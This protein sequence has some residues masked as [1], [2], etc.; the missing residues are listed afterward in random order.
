MGTIEIGTRLKGRPSGRARKTGCPAGMPM[1]RPE[2]G[3]MR[4]CRVAKCCG[5]PLGG[6]CP[7]GD[8]RL[9]EVRAA[10]KGGSARQGRRCTGQR[11]GNARL[12]L[13]QSF[14]GVPLNGDCQDGNHR[15]WNS[16]ERA[17][18]RAR[19]GRR[20]SREHG[21]FSIFIHPARPERKLPG[22]DANAPDRGCGMALLC[23]VLHRLR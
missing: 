3:R 8:G 23:E 14:R 21:I 7:D 2:G 4:G 12:L 11:A 9:W 18:N 1:Y 10:S 16:F 13:W 19:L 15:N 6:D 22:R 5:V 20:R 17:S